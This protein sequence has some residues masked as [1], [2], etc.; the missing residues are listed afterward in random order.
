MTKT[1]F[2]SATNLLNKKDAVQRA[3]NEISTTSKNDF[4]FFDKKE[5]KFV[6]DSME[7]MT[8]IARLLD[9]LGITYVHHSKKLDSVPELIIDSKYSDVARTLFEGWQ[10]NITIE[11]NVR[12]SNFGTHNR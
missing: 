3:L 7:I 8:K 1:D 2:T 6:S 12:L 9:S 4:A 5:S 10:S 11:Q